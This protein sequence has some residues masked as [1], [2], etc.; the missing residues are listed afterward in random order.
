MKGS[1]RRNLPHPHPHT[2]PLS[3]VIRSSDGNFPFWILIAQIWSSLR[4]FFCINSVHRLISKFLHLPDFNFELSSFDSSVM[5]FFNSSFASSIIFF[6]S[7]IVVLASDRMCAMDRFS[8]WFI[9]SINVFLILFLWKF[10]NKIFYCCLTS[11]I[12]LNNSD[13]CWGFCFV[14]DD[15]WGTLLRSV[16]FDVIFFFSSSMKI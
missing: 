11:S 12:A 7:F 14:S 4:W 3:V 6:T 2:L 10:C 15:G 8:H 13:C 1:G 9:S 16:G 5:E